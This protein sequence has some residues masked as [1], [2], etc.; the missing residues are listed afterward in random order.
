MKARIA[1]SRP[2]PTPATTTSA[3]LTPRAAALPPITSP[4]LPAAKG[5][6]FLAPLNPRDPAE[7]QNKVLPSLSEKRTLV[8]LKVASMWRTPEVTFFFG[9]LGTAFTSSLGVSILLSSFVTFVL[10]IFL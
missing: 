10:P 8:L 5:V 6:P 4:T 3:S 1:G 2:D 9:V 7:D